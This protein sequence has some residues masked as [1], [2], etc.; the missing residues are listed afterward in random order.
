MHSLTTKSPTFDKTT[1]PH[2]AKLFYALA[3]YHTTCLYL[4]KAKSAVRECQRQVEW[5]KNQL[6]I[7]VAA[8]VKSEDNAP[9]PTTV[10][11]QYENGQGSVEDKQL[12]GQALVDAFGNGVDNTIQQLLKNKKIS[13]VN[14]GL[15]SCV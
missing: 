8:Q 2:L 6:D 15:Y 10:N 3:A 7:L 5:A 1:D 13:R 9:E 4:D 11:V 14:R 12:T